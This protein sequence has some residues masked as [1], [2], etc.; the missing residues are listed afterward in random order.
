MAWRHPVE[1]FGVVVWKSRIGAYMHI[2]YAFNS[3]Q[4]CPAA[5]AI[6]RPSFLYPLFRVDRSDTTTGASYYGSRKI[7]L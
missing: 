1:R 5:S 6:G 2:I 4:R 7:V 3:G